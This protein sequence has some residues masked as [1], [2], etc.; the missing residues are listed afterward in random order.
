VTYGEILIVLI[1]FLTFVVFC[2]QYELG[3]LAV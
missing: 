1:A 2:A 3:I